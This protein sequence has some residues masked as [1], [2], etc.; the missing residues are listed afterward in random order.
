MALTG[1]GVYMAGIYRHIQAYTGNEAG[2]ATREG[3]LVARVGRAIYEFSMR[4]LN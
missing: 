4:W 1:K 3:P 2:L